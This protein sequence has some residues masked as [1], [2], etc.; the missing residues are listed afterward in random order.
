MGVALVALDQS[1]DEVR[2]LLPV[3]DP[4][5]AAVLTFHEDKASV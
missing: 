4:R 3:G 2:A 5:E 1:V